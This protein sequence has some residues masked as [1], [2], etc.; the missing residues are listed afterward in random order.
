MGVSKVAVVGCGMMGRGIVEVSAAAGIPTVA[1]KATPGSLDKAKGAIRKSFE[2]RVR[3]GKMT[4]EQVEEV[5]GRIEFTDDYAAIADADVVVES[6]VEDEALKIDVLKKIE[7]QMHPE[8]V[9]GTNTSSLRLEKLAD[10]LER[11]ERFVGLHFFSPVPAM[12]LVELGGT[13]KT[14]DHALQRSEEFCEQIG[15]TAVRIKAAPGYVVNR[16]LVPYL[17]H[18][19]YTLEAGI[20]TAEGIDTAMKL[21]CGH[22]MGPLA[23]SDLIG[24]D[25]VYAMAKTMRSELDDP[26]YEIP[27]TLE[28]L[29]SAG[30]LGRK[31]GIGI[32]DYSG[33]KPV[34]NPAI[35]L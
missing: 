11:P 2:R 26:R 16:L 4:E 31:S 6:A 10:S 5:F 18:A 24:L 21:G 20:A 28:Q 35:K 25:I 13:P 22:P 30:Q 3:K 23:L 34:L 14:G 19:I 1:V 33:D 12:A 32:Y 15:K 8:A 17:L 27:K 7:A 9:L 29:H